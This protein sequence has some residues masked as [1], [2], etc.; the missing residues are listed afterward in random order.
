MPFFASMLYVLSVIVHDLDLAWPVVGPTEAD[1]PLRVDP[2]AVPTSAVPA[3]R[4]QPIT[5]KRG[6]VAERLRAVQQGQPTHRLIGKAV[7]RRDTSP[8]EETSGSPVPEASYHVIPEC[9]RCY[10]FRKGGLD[11]WP[12]ATESV[13]FRVEDGRG[14]DMDLV[15][16]T[17]WGD[18]RIM[19]R[20]GRCVTEPLDQA[21]RGYQYMVAGV[22]GPG[23]GLSGCGA[24]GVSESAVADACGAASECE[25]VPSPPSDDSAF[26]LSRHL[27]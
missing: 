18:G 7:K 23:G 2:N 12:R 4:F 27:S 25:V 8:L 20:H 21:M 5:R 22:P 6:Q 24:P 14:V 17:E 15:D 9:T 19:N 13:F 16:Y 11:P 26:H 1:P 3:K 10:G